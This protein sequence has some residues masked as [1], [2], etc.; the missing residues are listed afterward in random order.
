MPLYLGLD[1]STQ[2]LTAVVIRVDGDE[3]EVVLERSLRY[4]EDFPH[5]GT[6]NGV[7]PGDDPLV[8]HSSPAVWADA[9]DELMGIL[10]REGLPSRGLR[11]VAGSGQQHGSV[12]LGGRYRTILDALDPRVPLADQVVDM[13][14]RPTAPIWMDS[15]TRAESEEIRASL[16]GDE[17][18]ARILGSRACERFTGPQ[19][20]KFWKQSR[21][22]YE[23]TSRIHLVSSFMASLLAGKDASIDPGD[24]AGMNLMDLARKAWS[25]EALEATAPGLRER[26]PEIREA[27]AIV[28]TL[29]PY[30]VERHGYPRDVQVVSWSGDNPCSLVGVGLVERGRVAISLGT[31]DTLFGYLE[32]P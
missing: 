9:L 25:P 24:G 13:L 4:D 2:S 18:L 12:Y 17:A 21:D 6:Q 19:I 31:S 7:L 22:L 28:G 8:A 1:A 27:W 5:Y 32:E 16:G 10:A 23:S 11:A 29:S 30:W 15:S 3:R 20:R 26:L 14:S